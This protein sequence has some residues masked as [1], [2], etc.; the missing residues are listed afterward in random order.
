LAASEPG[1]GK[2]RFASRLAP[3]TQYVP[4]G[5]WTCLGLVGACLQ[6]NKRSARPGSPAGWLLQH[7]AHQSL[8]VGLFPPTDRTRPWSG[9]ALRAGGL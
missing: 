8:A 9:S 7:N 3:A 5:V 1:F 4:I 6:A 2:V